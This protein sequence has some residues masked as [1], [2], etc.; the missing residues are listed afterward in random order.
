M[1]LFVTVD[2]IRYTF[3]VLE[4]TSGGPCEYRDRGSSHGE[5]TIKN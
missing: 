2:E 4:A 5:V 3:F 1:T